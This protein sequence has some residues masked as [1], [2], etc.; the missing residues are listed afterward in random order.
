MRR[1]KAIPTVLLTIL[2][3]ACVTIN[4]YFPAAAAEQAADRII[5]DVWGKQPGGGEKKPPSSSR[6][7]GTR[8]SLLNGLLDLVVAPAQAAEAD[9]SISSPAINRIRA[10]MRARHSQLAPYY[11]SGAIGL[12][13]DALIA[14][15]AFQSVPL[16]ARNTVK[17][18]VAHENTDRGAL[19]REIARVNGHPDWERDIRKTF[20]QR[21]VANARPGW[22]YQDSGGAWR[23]K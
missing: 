7:S 12:T 6:N 2:L 18:L 8:V 14:I 16:K 20:A 5:E 13:R 9:I 21:W 1:I 17:Q 15:R 19:Y 22:W 10:T 11:N 23:Q 4:I 3:T